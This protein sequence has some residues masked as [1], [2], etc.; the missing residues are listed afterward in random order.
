[1]IS[2]LVDVSTQ[3]GVFLKA[4]CHESDSRAAQTTRFGLADDNTPVLCVLLCWEGRVTGE[5][6]GQENAERPYLGRRR[7][8][9]FLQEDF[10]RR[11]SGGAE[12]EGVERSR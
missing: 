8:V 12:E 1:M 11:I 2:H 10:R 6:V 9:G 5:E 3:K 7:L 4:A